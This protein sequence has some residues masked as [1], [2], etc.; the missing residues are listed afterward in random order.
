MSKLTDA[1]KLLSVTGNYDHIS[2]TS[3]TAVFKETLEKMIYLATIKNGFRKTGLYPYNPD[4]IDKS[5][6]MPKLP[7]QQLSS[8]KTTST[9]STLTNATLANITPQDPTKINKANNIS[10]TP[11]STLDD[12]AESPVFPFNKDPI[13][14]SANLQSSVNQL[15]TLP[16]ASLFVDLTTISNSSTGTSSTIQSTSAI[17]FNLNSSY[18]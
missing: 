16:G 10:A 2:K 3:F 11:Q 9:V 5:C 7:Q 4:A 18:E 6:L 8:Q 1:L 12:S 17:D 15:S 13:K 14:N